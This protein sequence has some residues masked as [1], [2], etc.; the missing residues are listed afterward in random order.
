MTQ[1][2]QIGGVNVPYAF[3]HLGGTTIAPNGTAIALS[4]PANTGMVYFRA[5]SAAAYYTVGG[6][7]ATAS[8]YGFVPSGGND[9][10]FSVDNLTAVSVYAGTGGTV[11]IQYYS[12]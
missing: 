10:I 3:S 4:L 8:S 12:G 6:G 11:H 7:T 1:F 2:T 9:M 5:E